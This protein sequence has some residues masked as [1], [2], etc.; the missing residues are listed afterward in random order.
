MFQYS[1]GNIHSYG[2]HRVAGIV[3]A[4]KYATARV[5]LH[6]PINPEVTAI[7]LTT[8]CNPS[9]EAIYGDNHPPDHP[10]PVVAATVAGGPRHDGFDAHLMNVSSVDAD[11]VELYWAVIN[12]GH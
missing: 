5:P 6:H 8:R 7:L 9:G 11:D 1:P 10:I 12:P 3:R 4:G 2:M